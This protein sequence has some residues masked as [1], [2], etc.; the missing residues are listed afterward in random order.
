MPDALAQAL[1]IEGLWLIGLA[2]ALS[3]LVRGFS[4]FGTALIFVPLAGQVVSPLWVIIIIV[5]M[6]MFGPVPNLPR[7]WQYGTRPRVGWMLLGAALCLPLGLAALLRVSPDVFRYAASGIAMAAPVLLGLGVRWGGPLSRPVLLGTGGASGFLGGIA[8]LPGPPVILLYMAK[9]VSPTAMRADTML[10]FYGYVLLLLGLL[11]AQGR[12]EVLP[13]VVGLLMAV[14]NVAGNILG[15]RLFHPG[16][17][18]VYRGMAY[19][20]TIAA[21]VSGLPLWD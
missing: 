4:G 6:D 15:A 12:L 5:V 21:A 1:G 11:V 7:A 18:R 3:G 10:F 13:V 17:A 9:R 8:G 20:I 19:A 16:R 14:P 2:A